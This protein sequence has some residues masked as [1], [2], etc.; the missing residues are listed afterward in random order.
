MIQ[1]IR[2]EM[3][4]ILAEREGA[5]RADLILLLHP[6]TAPSIA[7]E[8]G[9]EKAPD[10]VAGIEVQYTRDVDIDEFEIVWRDEYELEEVGDDE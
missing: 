6:R 9:E 8:M 10:R 1:K 3:N 2:D 5:G 4:A 7:K